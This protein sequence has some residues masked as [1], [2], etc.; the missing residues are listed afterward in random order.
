VSTPLGWDEVEAVLE[1]GDP[2]QL[3]FDTSDVLDRVEAHGDLFG[4]DEEHRAHLPAA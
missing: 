3:R 1:G 2:E 4:Y